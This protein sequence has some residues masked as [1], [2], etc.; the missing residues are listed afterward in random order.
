MGIRN[1]IELRQ[2][3]KTDER[4]CATLDMKADFLEGYQWFMFQYY[5]RKGL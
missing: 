3:S 1:V 4:L 5:R 2:V